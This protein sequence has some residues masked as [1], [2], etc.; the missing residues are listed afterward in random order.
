[1]QNG[2]NNS[3]DAMIGGYVV[4]EHR[5]CNGWHDNTVTHAFAELAAAENYVEGRIDEQITR[6]D[7]GYAD[8]DT[9]LLN[10]DDRP[11]LHAVSPRIFAKAQDHLSRGHDYEAFAYRLGTA[12]A[13]HTQES[14]WS[15]VKYPYTYKVGE[16]EVF[17]T[18]SEAAAAEAPARPAAR[19]SSAAPKVG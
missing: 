9:W 15:R 8:D 2:G 13:R 14:E 19:P 4:V 5:H 1:M 12:I 7:G 18:K 11:T 16:T 17:A 6:R 3:G 10:H